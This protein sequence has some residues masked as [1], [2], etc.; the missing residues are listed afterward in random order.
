M[1]VLDDDRDEIAE[2][3]FIVIVDMD[4]SEIKKAEIQEREDEVMDKKISEECDEFWKEL[5]RRSKGKTEK[6]KEKIH[7]ELLE[8]FNERDLE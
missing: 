6:E 2:I 3:E 4:E 7:K 1:L 5:E 8:E